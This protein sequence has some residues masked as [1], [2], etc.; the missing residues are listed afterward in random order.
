MFSGMLET[1]NEEPVDVSAM[2]PVG[3]VEM[4]F[5]QLPDIPENEE[6]VAAESPTSTRKIAKPEP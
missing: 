1:P 4:P 5:E 2:V 3:Q 6:T